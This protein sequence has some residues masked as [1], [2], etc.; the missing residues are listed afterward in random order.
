[1]W[2]YITTDILISDRCDSDL[3]TATSCVGILQLII[4]I[5]DR[6][7]SDLHAATS[8]GGILQLIS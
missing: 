5:S 7:D 4:L 2:W 6:C 1:M 8:C 3:H